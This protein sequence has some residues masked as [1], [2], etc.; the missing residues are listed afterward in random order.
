MS[1]KVIHDIY[2]GTINLSDL[3]LS[4]G[5][6]APVGMFDMSN[7]NQLSTVS[8][9]DTI[10]TTSTSFTD[11]ANM[12]IVIT[13]SIDTYV[14]AIL[15][16]EVAADVQND[17]GYICIDIDGVPS[18][19]IHQNAWAVD[20][21]MLVGLHVGSYVLAGSRTI[22]AQWAS[23]DVGTTITVTTRRLTVLEFRR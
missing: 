2:D 17:Y 19:Q 22:K 3:S 5:G 8:A 13:P 14:L 23:E 1:K 16:A 7:L 10:T 9:T 6:E 11:M 18:E 21:K 4:T 15:T 20:R 12:E